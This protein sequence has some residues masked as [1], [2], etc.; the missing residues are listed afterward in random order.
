MSISIMVQNGKM[1][2]MLGPKGVQTP[3]HVLFADDIMVFCNGTKKN[4]RNLIDL[5][6]DYGEPSGHWINPEN[7]R[8]FHGAL[9]S[10]R[11]SKIGNV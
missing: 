11:I 6:R 4:L 10:R 2:P 3:S 8:F 7:C 5:F 9:S 1:K